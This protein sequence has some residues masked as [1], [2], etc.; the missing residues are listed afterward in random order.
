MAKHVLH[1]L[2]LGFNRLLA[3][4]HEGSY[5]YACTKIIDAPRAKAFRTPIC[6]VL[7]QHWKH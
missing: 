2:G 1:S 4:I 5:L 6:H 7:H 3:A